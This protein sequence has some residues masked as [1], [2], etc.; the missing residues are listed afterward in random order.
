MDLVEKFSKEAED[1]LTVIDAEIEKAVGPL[2][3]EKKKLQA[4]VKKFKK[5]SSAGNTAPATSDED[6]VAA[7]GHLTSQDGVDT[8]K[9]S[10]IASHLGVDSRSFARRLSGGI[11]G[12]TGTKDDGYSVV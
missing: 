4:T 12:I 7:I 6:L 3:A 10:D 1:R 8:V 11:E 9:A 2:V 5:G